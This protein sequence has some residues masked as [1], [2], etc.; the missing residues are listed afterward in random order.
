MTIIR[1]LGTEDLQEFEAATQLKDIFKRSIPE[2]VEGEIIILPSFKCFGQE[3]RDI[4]LIVFGRFDSGFERN[5]KTKGKVKNK[6]K[7]D[8]IFRKVKI[9]NFFCCIE[10]K[11]HPPRKIQF[12]SNSRILV[13]YK[14]KWSD[15]T[16]QSERQKYSI[17]NY[18]QETVQWTPYI[19]N[20]IWLRNISKESLKENYES[21][22]WLH[23]CLPSDF[24]IDWFLHLLCSQ[25]ISYSHNESG[26]YFLSCTMREDPILASQKI[27]KAYEYFNSVKNDIGLL[28]RQKL[29]KITKSNLLKGQ[30]YAQSIG[31]KLV[32][33]R[34]R[35]GTGKTIKLL[36]IAHDLCVVEQQRCLILTYNKALVSDIRRTLALADITSDIT[37]PT[38]AVKTIHSFMYE[39]LKGFGIIRASNQDN[40][41]DNY[42]DLKAT[43]LDYLKQGLLTDK[44]VQKLMKSKQHEVA[45][46]SILIDES[47]DWPS[48]EREILFELFKPE[49]FIVAD[50]VDQLVRGVEHTSWTSGV[51]YHK[52]IINEKKSLR[53][54]ANLCRFCSS[55]A[56]KVNLN[57]DVEP[58]GDLGGG[59]VLILQGAYS[60]KLHFDL[61]ND[62]LNSGNKQYEMLFLVPPSLVAKEPTRKFKWLDEWQALG[63]PLWD[64]TSVDIRSDFPRD[65]AQ[66]RVLQY[67]SCR[68]LEG[69]TVVCLHLDSFFEHKMSWY[70]PDLSN[71]LALYSADEM[72]IRF[73][74]QWLM[75][76]FTRA[77]DTLVISFQNPNSKVAKILKEIGEEKDF[78]EIIK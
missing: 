30:K 66:H 47:Q 64:G 70:D 26:N 14:Q 5:I 41:L 39:L 48:N 4:D 72:K 43:L 45:W 59:Q 34:G 33:I 61:L 62:C 67:D 13:K 75:M 27:Q 29:E 53:Q 57:W 78:I 50:G 25:N 51:N 19:C 58:K 52:P 65:P 37:A 63:I 44:D 60:S 12:T 77:I 17:K 56:N 71:E 32:V 46:D 16:D 31:T 28:T 24:G 36:H 54:K 55:F 49:S 3:I 8:R 1:I 74:F 40:F 21:S 9:D 76:P 42:E 2:E 68:G 20:L 23:N 22:Q 38:I 10:V 15:A 7:E 11:D 18:L 35:A 69:W 6:V 73:A